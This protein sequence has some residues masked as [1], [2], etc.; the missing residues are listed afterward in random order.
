MAA[1]RGV[2]QHGPDRGAVRRPDDLRR[3]DETVARVHLSEHGREL[4]PRGLRLH[5]QR[6]FAHADLVVL[7]RR[8]LD[9]PRGEGGAT[10]AGGHIGIYRTRLMDH[11]N[12]RNAVPAEGEA[13]P[14]LARSG[15]RAD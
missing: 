7:T 5:P 15:P 10:R 8:R 13:A 14:A 6:L 12:S 2:Q 9:G 11:W 4:E 3:V 1:R